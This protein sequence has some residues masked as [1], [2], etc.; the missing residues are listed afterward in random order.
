MSKANPATALCRYEGCGR[1][2]PLSGR[3][4]KGGHRFCTP[5]HRVAHHRRLRRGNKPVGGLLTA[6]QAPEGLK[7]SDC[8]TDV[9]TD[10]R[11]AHKTGVKIALDTPKT[12][13][14]QPREW[15]RVYF[16]DEAPAIGS[17]L[18]L[19]AVDRITPKQVRIRDHAGRTAKLTPAT[20]ANLKPIAFGRSA[21]MERYEARFPNSAASEQHE[22]AA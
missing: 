9:K 1:R 10:A 18:R 12:T 11:S 22:A 6:L 7:V 15:L 19:I 21:A 16:H 13:T 4:R 5:K 2:F 14:G 8:V 20:Y 3:K 17:G